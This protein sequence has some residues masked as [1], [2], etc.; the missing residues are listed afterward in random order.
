MGKEG[1]KLYAKYRDYANSFN[2]WIDIK[3]YIY[4]K[5][6]QYFPKWYEARIKM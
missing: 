2:S 5:M 4:I 6:S 3:K 1:A